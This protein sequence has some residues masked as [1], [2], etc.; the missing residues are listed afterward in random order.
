[1]R[2]AFS[3]GRTDWVKPRTLTIEPLPVAVMFRIASAQGGE[4]I[5]L[6]AVAVKAGEVAPMVPP[7]TTA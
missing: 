6:E 4:V 7:P 1:M 3:L 2:P 5:A